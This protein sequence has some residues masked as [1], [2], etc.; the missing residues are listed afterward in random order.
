VSLVVSDTTPL[1]YLI[2]TGQIDVLPMLFGK[3]LIPPA[4]IREM[5]HSLAPARVAAWAGNLPAWAE[6]R[7]PKVD[8]ELGIGAGEDEAISLALELG[9]VALLLDDSKARV[10]AKGRGILT[11]GT[12]AILDLA[13]ESGLLDFF[14]A[15]AKLRETNFRMQETL[16]APVLAKVRARKNV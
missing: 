3:I 15:I 7:G 10:F 9:N 11:I 5:R 13:D 6:V 2:L 8:S 1:N 14:D 16:L 4:V 12:V